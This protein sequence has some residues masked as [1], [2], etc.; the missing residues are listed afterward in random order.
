VTAQTGFLKGFQVALHLHAALADGSHLAE[1]HHTSWMR[2]MRWSLSRIP[3]ESMLPGM[4]RTPQVRVRYVAAPNVPAM[5]QGG[6]SSEPASLIR[7]KV[8]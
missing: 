2:L 3:I 4:H 8:P 1:R 5:A 6:V 7:Y